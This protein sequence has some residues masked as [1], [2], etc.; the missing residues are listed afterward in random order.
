MKIAKPQTIQAFDGYID[1]GQFHPSG[2]SIL[3]GRF[4]A[5]LTVIMDVQ[6]PQ[7]QE[8][9]VP[10]VHWAYELDRMIEE[11]TDPPLQME[12]FPRMDFGREQIYFVNGDENV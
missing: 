1:G 5:V 3:P 12:N 4:R 9:N 8:D 11:S 2:A 7:Q 6:P 10:S